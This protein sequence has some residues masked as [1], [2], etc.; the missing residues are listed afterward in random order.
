MIEAGVV[1]IVEEKS[2]RAAPE[3]KA[4]GASPQNKRARK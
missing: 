3:N 2:E 4:I 1:E